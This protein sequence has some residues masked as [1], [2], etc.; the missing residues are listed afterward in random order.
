MQYHNSKP[1]KVYQ[2]YHSENWKA[3]SVSNMLAVQTWEPV[4]HLQNPCL[5]QAQQHPFVTKHGERGKM[6]SWSS[7]AAIL[8]SQWTSG[9]ERVSRSKVENDSAWHPPSAA[10]LVD[11][12]LYVHDMCVWMRA[13]VY[14]GKHLKVRGQLC[15]HLSPF[16]F[17]RA[18]GNQI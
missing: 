16:T 10:S 11:V 9:S 18:S 14:P 4:F 15:S 6:D 17:A 1:F 7:L 2:K 3:R 8:Q 13:G 5:S 12:S